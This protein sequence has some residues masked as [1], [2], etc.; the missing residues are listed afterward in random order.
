MVKF[1]KMVDESQHFENWG[2]RPARK[3][4]M[5]KVAPPQSKTIVWVTYLVK[6]EDVKRVYGK[7]FTDSKLE[8]YLQ[9]LPS[10]FPVGITE[11]RSKFRSTYTQDVFVPR[12]KFEGYLN[13]EQ[14]LN[15]ELQSNIGDLEYVAF[16][17]RLVED[18]LSNWAAIFRA[19]GVRYKPRRIAFLLGMQAQAGANSP[20]RRAFVRHYLAE[21][22]IL[23]I[24][25]SF[26]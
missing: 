16:L 22:Q 1:A 23:R 19:V 10:T 25:F 21:P 3:I 24:I 11:R 17:E 8:Q 20:I 9:M 6:R 4:K 2:P 14:Q 13:F 5:S 18:T 26:A 12:L 15:V 7:A